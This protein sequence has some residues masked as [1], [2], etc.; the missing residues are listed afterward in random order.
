MPMKLNVGDIVEL[1]KTHP[2]GGN[3]FEIK[4]VGMDFRI[5]CKKCDKQLWID[6]PTLEKRIKKIVETK[7]EN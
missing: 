6:R 2:C 1:R 4:R 7:E 3:I 5:L